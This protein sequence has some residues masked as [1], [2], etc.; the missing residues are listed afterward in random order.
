MLWWRNTIYKELFDKAHVLYFTIDTD[1]SLRRLE[2]RTL[3]EQKEVFGKRFRKDKYDGTLL[4][5]HF[6]NTLI[7]APD[8]SKMT[9]NDKKNFI[10]Q[11]QQQIIETYKL[12]FQDEI[13]PY[14]MLD[15]MM[16]RDELGRLLKR[17][18]VDMFF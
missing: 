12:V 17:R 10:R 16:S 6:I 5:L 14:V 9:R 15:G 18:V 7:Y 8:G 4:A 11:S 3:E 13:L 1:E 2:M